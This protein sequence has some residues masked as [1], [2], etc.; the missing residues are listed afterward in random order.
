MVDEGTGTTLEVSASNAQGSAPELVEEVRVG[1]SPE[2]RSANLF[3][4]A[5]SRAARSFL[6]YEPTN[7]AIRRFITDL[8]EKLK[9]VVA[10]IGTL[11]FEVQPFEL[12]LRDE[13]VYVETDRERSL[14]FRMFRDGVRRIV[15]HDEVTWEEILRL[16]E[17]LSVRY[18]GVRQNED[19]LVTLLWKAGFEHIDI[20]AVEGFVPEDDGAASAVSSRRHSELE[21]PADWDLPPRALEGHV[22]LEYRPLNEE[23]LQAL[24]REEAS[25]LLPANAV[26]AVVELLELAADPQNDVAIDSI[27]PFVGEVR[28]FL[29]AEGQVGHLT[30]VVRACQMT[31]AR[32]PESV[33]AIVSTFGDKQALAKILHSTPKGTLHPPE[34]LLDLLDLLPTD[35]LGHLVD[36]VMEERGEAGRRLTRQLIERYAADQPDY[37]VARMRTAEPS[38]V[39]DLLRACSNVMPDR[40]LDAAIEM[41]RHSDPDVIHEVLLR[42]EEAPGGAKVSRAL[43]KMLDAPDEEVRLKVWSLL[44]GRREHAAFAPLTR[45]IEQRAQSGLASAEAELAGRT[46]AQLAPSSALAV[47]KEWLRPKGL[48][49][50]WVETPAHLSLTF[51]TI[52]GLAVLPGD[53]P[54]RLIREVAERSQDELKHHCLA[55]LGRRRREAEQRG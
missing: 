54:E 52:A 23:A 13:A 7:D 24:V 25:H 17:V 34:E 49:G 12:R 35:R 9:A 30:E 11:D 44:A 41:S 55:A 38:V 51:V 43:L 5:L 32:S 27:V 37:I 15:I 6:L 19:D 29:L 1:Q 16:L 10:Q 26:R 48:I 14:A 33:A 31:F 36:L 22:A 46:L 2:G 42:F 3:L 28:D 45:Y 47:F 21:I 4:L 39:C 20:D 50:R 53:E 18:T 40:A 8:Q